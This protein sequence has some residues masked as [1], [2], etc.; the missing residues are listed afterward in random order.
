MCKA[1]T[2][3]WWSYCAMCGY[4][5]AAAISVRETMRKFDDIKEWCLAAAKREGD[6]EVGAGEV[7]TAYWCDDC[8]NYTPWLMKSV[9]CLRCAANDK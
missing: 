1:E 7:A 8:N 6:S 2:E 4:H 9:G 3:H 5:I